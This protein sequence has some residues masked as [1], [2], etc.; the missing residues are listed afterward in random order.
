[1]KMGCWNSSRRAS[2]CAHRAARAISG[3][4]ALALA[5]GTMPTNAKTE[6]NPNR[7]LLSSTGKPTI[8]L[9][10]LSTTK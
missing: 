4:S 5:A 7:M 3:G 6:T 2:S 9:S 8:G 10:L 1:M